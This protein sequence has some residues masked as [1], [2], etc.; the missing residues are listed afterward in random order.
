MN[1]Q[2][3]YK[4]LTILFI[5]IIGF[6]SI[7]TILLPD[8]TFSESENRVLSKRPKFT[9][10]KL[11]DNRYTKKYE[12]YKTDQFIGRD[13]FMNI[14]ASSDLLLG[15][16]DNNSVFLSDDGYLIENFTPMSDK[17]INDTLLAINDFAKKYNKSNTY[18]GIVPTAVSIHEDKLPNFSPVQ[19]QD[20]YLREFYKN[21][22]PEIKTLDITS[23]LSKSA[24]EYLYYKTD[25]HWTTL[26]A[27]KAYEIAKKEMKLDNVNSK[28]K[29]LTVSTNF[30]GTLTAKSGFSTSNDSIDAYLNINKN[31]KISVSYPK[32]G[33]KSPSLYD[34]S[35][36]ETKDKYAMFLSGNHPIIDIRTN[37]KTTNTLIIFKDSYAN[38]FIP[39]LT[40]HYSKITVID[41]RY[42][43]DDLYKL[44]DENQYNDILFL[45]NANT[46]FSD[47]SLIP[48]LQNN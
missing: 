24:D 36:L 18:V 17:K 10:E 6:F 16:K 9:F 47:S 30:N 33:K 12:K 35:K 43:Y 27:S 29:P 8:K 44:M 19:K 39:F 23:A 20:T 45:Y 37:A 42:Y 41:P 21:L 32:V 38:C 22:I 28:F 15:K 1:K 14:K 31:L 26:A 4:I 2:K 46:F 5:G 40:E 7:L 3:Y 48:V 13:F 11:L 25:H 34:T